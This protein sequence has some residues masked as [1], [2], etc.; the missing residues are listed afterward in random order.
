MQL[1]TRSEIFK[2][3]LSIAQAIWDIV[4]YTHIKT[5]VKTEPSLRTSKE[6]EKLIKFLKKQKNI[7]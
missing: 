4:Y 2:I 6:T 3:K 7:Q 1:L 5:I